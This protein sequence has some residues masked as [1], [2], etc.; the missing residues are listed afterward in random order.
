MSRTDYENNLDELDARWEISCAFDALDI[1]Q[2]TRLVEYAAR[3]LNRCDEYDTNAAAALARI[4][5]DEAKPADADL[6]RVIA[7]AMRHPVRSQR[8]AFYCEALARTMLDT[9]LEAA[10]VAGRRLALAFLHAY[11]IADY[12]RRQAARGHKV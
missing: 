12:D 11:R 10:L 2:E 5:L 7:G 8:G 9:D 3:I 4:V 6:A 1:Y